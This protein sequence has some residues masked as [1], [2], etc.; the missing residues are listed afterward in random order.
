MNVEMTPVGALI[1]TPIRKRPPVQALRCN[2]AW[3]GNAPQVHADDSGLEAPGVRPRHLLSVWASP[4][5]PECSSGAWAGW[6]GRGHRFA[7]IVQ[8]PDRCYFS[9][10]AL[11]RFAAARPPP[12]SPSRPGSRAV[13]PGPTGRRRRRCERRA[14]RSPGPECTTPWRGAPRTPGRRAAGAVQPRPGVGSNTRGGSGRASARASWPA[15]ISGTAT[16]A[17]HASTSR[18]IEA[19]P[20]MPHPGPAEVGGHV[21]PSPADG[22]TTRG[23]LF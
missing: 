2:H 7:T 10:P 5:C 21:L 8:T 15:R 20:R 4:A 22:G 11:G 14:A 13:G 23:H 19:R 1:F 9:T 6:T 17:G 16:A 18:H 12:P 3:M